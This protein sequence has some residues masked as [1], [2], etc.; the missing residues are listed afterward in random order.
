MMQNTYMLSPKNN[1][2]ITMSSKILM[3]LISLLM[4]TSLTLSGCVDSNSMQGNSTS[5]DKVTISSQGTLDPEFC[6][7]KGLNDKVIMIESRYCGHCQTT[8]PKF[9]DACDEKGIEPVVIDVSVQEDQDLMES[10]GIQTRYTPT[11]LFGCDHYVG[12][13]DKQTYLSLIDSFKSGE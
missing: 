9:L 3:I 4:V 8:K 2:V 1:T 12:A 13:M 5:D 6:K 11:F 7:E 10:Y